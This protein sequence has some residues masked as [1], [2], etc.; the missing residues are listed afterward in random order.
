MWVDVSN[1]DVRILIGSSK[2]AVYVHEQYTF[3]QKQSGTTGT[4]S[5]DLSCNACHLYSHYFVVVV[6]VV[7]LIVVI[8]N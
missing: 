2:I 7:V 1:G 4:K 8:S 5:V 3:G 6:V